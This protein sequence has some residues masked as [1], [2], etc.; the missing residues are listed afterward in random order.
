[1]GFL[2]FLIIILSQ[3][4]SF[5][6]HRY[7]PH[8]Q[9]RHPIFRQIELKQH[10]HCICSFILSHKWQIYTFH[11]NKMNLFPRISTPTEKF[12]HTLINTDILHTI[13]P[14]QRNI[15]NNVTLIRSVNTQTS[16]G[17]FLILIG[18]CYFI[19][20]IF[21][22]NSFTHLIRRCNVYPSN[23]SVLKCLKRA[24]WKSNIYENQ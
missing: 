19:S 8:L 17:W 18:K 24:G 14:E 22:P 15:L 10:I 7:F 11:E 2:S 4:C 5:F 16:F 12:I 20:C 21:P 1:M 3:N 13:D 9:L 6:P 23:H